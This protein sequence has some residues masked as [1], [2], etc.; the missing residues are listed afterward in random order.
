VIIFPYPLVIT[1]KETALALFTDDEVS[2]VTLFSGVLVALLLLALLVVVT[3]VLLPLTI[4]PFVPFCGTV[5]LLHANNVKLERINKKYFFILHLSP[6]IMPD[7][8]NMNTA[9][10]N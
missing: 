4:V 5:F 1:R 7:N 8:F 10:V 3:V 2:I 6:N 9:V